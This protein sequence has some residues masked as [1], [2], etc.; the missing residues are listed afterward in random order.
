[1]SGEEWIE[2]VRRA[3]TTIA[4]GQGCGSIHTANMTKGRN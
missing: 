1:M 2:F 4:R 3:Q